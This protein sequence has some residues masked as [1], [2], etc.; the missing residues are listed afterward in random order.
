MR[1]VLPGRASV[2]AA[3]VLGLVTVLHLGAHLTG[4]DQVAD[5]SQWFLMPLLALTLALAAPRPHGRLVRLVL[6]AL[7]FSWLGDT[8][9]DVVPEDLA[10]VT[11]LGFFAVAQVLY[12]VAF[13]P[14]R[15]AG[16][17]GR[18]PVA[19]V[20][21]AAA[22]VALVVACAPGAGSLLAPAVVYGAL[23]ATM[24]ALSTFHRVAG[25]G[26][27]LFLVSDSLI[28]LDAFVDGYALPAH[29]FWVMLTYVAGQALLVAGVLLHVRRTGGSHPGHPQTAEVAATRDVAA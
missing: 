26:G 8:A 29:G 15:R 25:I 27:A 24:A 23:L 7:G 18:R 14:L 9:P 22:F 17:V 20:G 3:A 16:V 19:L 10:F 28:A 2:V 21:Y 5:V 13:W 1:H 12:V 11:M 6:V 4:A